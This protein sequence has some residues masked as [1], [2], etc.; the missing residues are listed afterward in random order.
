MIRRWQVSIGPM[1]HLL[2]D[3][4]ILLVDQPDEFHK[5][6]IEAL[7]AGE[8]M[9]VVEKKSEIFRFFVDLDHQGESRLSA[10]EICAIA[11]HMNT[12][13]KKRCYIALTQSRILASGKVK[14][15]VHFHWPDLLVNK[16]DAI[17]LRNQILMTLPEGPDW[18]KAID[19]S[20]YSGSGLR[21]VW[22]HK[23]EGQTDYPPYT[24][25]KTV[26]TGGTIRDLP[27]EPAVDTLKLFSVRTDE[28]PAP[29]TELTQNFSKLEEYINKYMDGHSEARVLRVFKTRSDLSHCVQTDSRYCERLKKN[30]RRNHVWFKIRQGT[31]RQMC[32]DDDCKDFSGKPYILPPS[33]VESLQQNGAVAEIDSC[34]IS[35][36]DVFSLPKRV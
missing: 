4:G 7:K 3:G 17:K 12:V 18:D 2:M 36:R 25:W 16:T 33:I 5:E 8:K 19:A 30:H 32:L 24:P 21:L 6:Y 13:T 31:I 15:G 23:R 34:N 27:T 20:V 1:T 28:V 9:Y 14:T 26:S 10:S 35:F 11:K 22:S 29:K